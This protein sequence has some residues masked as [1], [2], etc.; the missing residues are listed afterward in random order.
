MFTSQKRHANRGPDE[1]TSLSDQQSGMDPTGVERAQELHR[2]KA[3]SLRETAQTKLNPNPRGVVVP[4]LD[5]VVPLQ[6]RNP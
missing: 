6:G 2:T 1:K 4:G 3:Q 5:Q